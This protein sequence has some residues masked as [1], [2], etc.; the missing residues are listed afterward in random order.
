M[1]LSPHNRLS[2]EWHAAREQVGWCQMAAM[3]AAS[4]APAGCMCADGGVM[5]IPENRT[6][7]RVLSYMPADGSK[8]VAVTVAGKKR[9]VHR[10]VIARIA[11]PGSNGETREVYATDASA[12]CIQECAVKAGPMQFVPPALLSAMQ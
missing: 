5:L 12:V 4:V 11:T 10:A 2:S 8:P 3:Q 7:A 9:S 6:Q 1:S